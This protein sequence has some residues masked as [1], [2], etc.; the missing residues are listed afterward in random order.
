[1]N[2]QN[3]ED[4]TKQ[5]IKEENQ[6][7]NFKNQTGHYGKKL[8]FFLKLKVCLLFRSLIRYCGG[9]GVGEP[10]I[11]SPDRYSAWLFLA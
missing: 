4:T 1:M 7:D 3:A 10:Y 2:G 5:N 11:L 8:D 9:R 6:Y